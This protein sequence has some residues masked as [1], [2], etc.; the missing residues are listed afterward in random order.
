[1]V[2][3]NQADSTRYA[4]QLKAGLEAEGCRVLLRTVDFALP[5]FQ[6]VAAAVHAD[7]SQLLFDAMDSRGNAALC[8]APD[9]AGVTVAAKGTNVQNSSTR[10]STTSGPRWPATTRTGPPCCPSGSWRAGR[11]RSG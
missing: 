8:R 2:A 7:G 10:R 6:A 1:M 9:E 4:G 5:N 11:A 3:H